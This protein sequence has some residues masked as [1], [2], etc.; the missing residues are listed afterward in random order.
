LKCNINYWEQ[1]SNLPKISAYSFDY[2]N[3]L[4]L[5]ILGKLGDRG[6]IPISYINIV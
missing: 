2:S 6:G 1:A 4:M 5:L 3:M